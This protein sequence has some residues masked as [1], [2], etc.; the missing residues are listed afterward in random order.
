MSRDFV[1]PLSH[2]VCRRF[3]SHTY[4]IILYDR[5]LCPC[6]S[7]AI[8][9][10]P[11]ST[12]RIRNMPPWS[13][14]SAGRMLK[15]CGGHMHKHVRVQTIDGH[16]YEGTTINI[17][18]SILYLQITRHNPRAYNAIRRWFSANCSLLPCYIRDPGSTKK[19]YIS[20]SI[21]ER[22]SSIPI[23]NFSND[24]FE[25][26]RRYEALHLGNLWESHKDSRKTPGYSFAF[27]IACISHAA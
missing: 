13:R 24:P 14:M 15:H 25:A 21:S 3:L 27:Y 6:L 20:L 26:A 5:R 18:R 23:P 12:K 11:S 1:T 19:P 8:L 22:R 4:V 10:L 17:D 16:V 7:R 2:Y 9:Q